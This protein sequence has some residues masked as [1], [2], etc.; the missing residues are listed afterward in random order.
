M[1]HCRAITSYFV[2]GTLLSLNS[3]PFMLQVSLPLCSTVV[4][5]CISG[6]HV[7]RDPHVLLIYSSICLTSSSFRFY[8][9]SEIARSRLPVQ[10]FLGD[11]FLFLNLDSLHGLVDISGLPFYQWY[12]FPTVAIVIINHNTGIKTRSAD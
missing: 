12:S 2:S 11:L 5:V 8:L 1:C 9:C 6:V 4:F 7:F 10:L 3:F